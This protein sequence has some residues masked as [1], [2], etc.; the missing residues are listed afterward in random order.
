MKLFKLVV[1]GTAI[2]MCAILVIIKKTKG[3]VQ[4]TI[5]AV[6]ATAAEQGAGNDS[7][8]DYPFNLLVN[9]EY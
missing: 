7:I 6:P 8:T 1:T 2:T 9:L 3:L 4:Q 5:T